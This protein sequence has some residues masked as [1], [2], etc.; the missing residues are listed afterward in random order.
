MLHD[1]PCQW[2][3]EGNY[4]R[5]HYHIE[6]QPY[7]RSRS[8]KSSPKAFRDFDPH[9]FLL[10]R[11]ISTWR[12]STRNMFK[13]YCTNI[14]CQYG[15]LT[16]SFETSGARVKSPWETHGHRAIPTEREL[17]SGVYVRV[18]INRFCTCSVILRL[19]ENSLLHEEVSEFII[20]Q[21]AFPKNLPINP[22][23]S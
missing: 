23:N 12:H 4:R 13:Q 8:S 6:A 15:V 10:S 3:R 11:L 1:F 17:S 19:A 5:V 7:F 2:R 21:V 18:A 14:V 16:T 20:S 9:C 22:A